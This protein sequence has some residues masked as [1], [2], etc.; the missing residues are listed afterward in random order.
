MRSRKKG[1]LMVLLLSMTVISACKGET[2]S[3]EAL[4]PGP[5]LSPGYAVNDPG[6]L[7]EREQIERFVRTRMMGTDGIY[8]NFKDTE[9]KAEVATG[10]E[11]LSESSSLYM[12]TA[13]RTAEKKEF[14]EAWTSARKT[15][16]QDWGFSYRYSPKWKKRFP[17]GASVDELRLLRALYEAGEVFQDPT[18]T[19]EADQLGER[20][21]R[22]HVRDGKLRD[23]YDSTAGVTNGFLTLCYADMRTLWQFPATVEPKKLVEDTLATVE[24]G[25]LSDSFPFYETR[26]NYETQRYE[27]EGIRTVESLLTILHLTEMGREKDTSIRF[28]KERLADGALYGEYSRTG[29]P[30]NRV[31]STAIYALVGMIA[32]ER[33]DPTLYNMAVERMEAYRVTKESSALFGGFGNDQLDEAYSFDN[34]M[35]LLAYTY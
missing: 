32:A 9:Q 24:G 7:Q 10:H 27:S 26:Y 17:V 1:I 34:L 19:K 33:D 20:F 28:I 35:A 13:A 6:R 15:F 30:M 12:R 25:Y 29:E 3:P 23:F 21:V 8:T 18:Y 4:S 22:Y 14:D 11:L 2:K 16:E 31:E 5:L